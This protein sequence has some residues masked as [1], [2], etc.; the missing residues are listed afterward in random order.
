MNEFEKDSM[1]NDY[2]Q[3]VDEIESNNILKSVIV[4]F[5]TIMF[6]VLYYFFS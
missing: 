2:D 4:I 1:H 5:A 3:H 6:F